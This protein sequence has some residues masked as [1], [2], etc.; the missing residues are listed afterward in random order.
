MLLVS[1]NTFA[2]PVL[3]LYQVADLGFLEWW[4]CNLRKVLGHAHFNYLALPG[5]ITELCLAGTP[6]SAKPQAAPQLVWK[7]IY[8]LFRT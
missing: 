2:D 3:D 8:N 4:G 6:T 7:W 1:R 5:T